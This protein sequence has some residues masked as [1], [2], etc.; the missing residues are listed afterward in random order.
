[1]NKFKRNQNFLSVFDVEK[2]I[3]FFAIL[4]FIF[5]FLILMKFLRSR[6]S[7]EKLIFILE[8]LFDL[9]STSLYFGPIVL[10]ILFYNTYFM[11][12]KS[13]LTNNIKTSKIILNT[14]EVIQ[15]RE[16]VLK[17]DKTI[18]WLGKL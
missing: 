10:I 1:M 3:L 2:S 17:S 8:I 9:R 7:K 15:H 16:D 4:A 14:S 6:P 13:I 11:I 18:C 5:T 12:Y